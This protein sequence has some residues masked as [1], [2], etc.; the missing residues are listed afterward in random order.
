M[1]KLLIAALFLPLF[2]LSI[3]LNGLLV[4]M[5][6][7]A[8]RF[9]LLLLWPQIGVFILHAARQPVPEGFVAW[10]LLSSAFY[11]LRLLTVR[12]LGLWAGFLASS[13]L[14]L[15]WARHGANDFDM[16]IFAFWFS[17]PSA[18]LFLLAGALARRFG[19]A[20]SGLYGGLAR[21]APR[22][23]G[24]LAFT[25]LAAI[26]TPPSPGFF[27]MLE[28]LRREDTA[29]ALLFIWLL[30]G[31][32]AIWLMQGFLSGRNDSDPAKDIG[33]GGTLLFACILGVMVFA[34]LYLKGG[35]L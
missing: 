13:S 19:A 1:M 27:A 22:L 8:A 34:S 10:S 17:L 16:H 29:P 33:R 6:N 26:A 25:L 24:L 30:W 20:Y 23:S 5:G 4:R 7:P 28:L 21:S 2:P 14:S 32:A 15:I 12:D 11:A 3:A 18:L 35:S 31:W 9:L